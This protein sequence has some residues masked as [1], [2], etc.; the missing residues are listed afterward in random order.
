MDRTSILIV[1]DDTRILTSL[2]RALAS[3]ELSVRTAPGAEEALAALARE[4]ADVVLLDLKMPGMDGMELLRILRERMPDID[5]IM[6]TAY[7]E[8]PTVAEAM[9]VGAVEFLVKPL[10]LQQLRRLLDRIVEDRATRAARRVGAARGNGDIRLV[11]HDPAMI[12]IFKIVGQVAGT[13]T[14][15][16]IRGESGTGKELIAREIHRSSPYAASIA[17]SFQSPSRHR[18]ASWARIRPRSVTA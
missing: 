7:D 9:R 2:T 15:V 14:N 6:M 13:R 5:V 4:P 10:N 1:D 17:R 8:L 3:P 16:V 12:E 18:L 11:G